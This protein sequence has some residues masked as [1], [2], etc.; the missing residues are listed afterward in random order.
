MGSTLT[1]KALNLR[2]HV[3]VEASSL[4]GRC[5]AIGGLATHTDLDGDA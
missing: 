2:Y 4:P 5:A 1:R 3:E